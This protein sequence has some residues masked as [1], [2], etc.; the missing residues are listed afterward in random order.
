M[1]W[2]FTIYR[3]LKVPILFSRLVPI[4]EKNLV[5][6]VMDLNDPMGINTDSM[7]MAIDPNDP[8]GVLMNPKE[9]TLVEIGL[10]HLKIYVRPRS[11]R[12]PLRLRPWTR[13]GHNLYY[14]I[15]M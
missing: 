13:I 7:V 9:A 12:S 2:T 3:L 10:R 14:C 6:V 1:D 11:H 4:F 15:P 5:V 8:S